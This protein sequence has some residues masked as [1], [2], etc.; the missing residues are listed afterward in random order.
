MTVTGT[1]RP[2]VAARRVGYVIAA[3]INGTM[4]YLK[5]SGW[6]C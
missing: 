1:K 5:G 6:R 3:L 4:L 2:P